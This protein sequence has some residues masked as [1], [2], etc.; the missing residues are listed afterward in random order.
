MWLDMYVQQV[1]IVKIIGD[2]NSVTV[3][4]GFLQVQIAWLPRVP[5]AFQSQNKIY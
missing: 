5:N 1:V 4:A 2:N 3:A